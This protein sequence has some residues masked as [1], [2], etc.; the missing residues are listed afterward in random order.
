MPPWLWVAQAV[1]EMR[2][3]AALKCIERLT[4]FQHPV[5]VKGRLERGPAMA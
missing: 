2:S 1:Q 4:K 3:D 5:Q